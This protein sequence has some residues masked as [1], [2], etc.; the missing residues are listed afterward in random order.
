ETGGGPWRP[1]LAQRTGSVGV[2]FTMV[3]LLTIAGVDPGSRR[4]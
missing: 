1:T 2:D 4:Q 3:D